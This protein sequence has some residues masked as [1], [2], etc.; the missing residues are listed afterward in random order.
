MSGMRLAMRIESNGLRPAEIATSVLFG[1]DVSAM[2]LSRGPR[3]PPVRALEDSQ[4]AALRRPPCLVAFSGGRDS[5]ALLAVAT[6]AARREGLA[7]PVPVTARYPT[8]EETRESEWQQL[9]V[10][11]LGLTDW[12]RRDFIE[13]AD[14]IGPIARGLME[15]HG[16]QYPYNVHLLAPFMEDARGGTFVTGLGGDEAFTPGSRALAVITGRVRP[17]TRDLLRVTASLAPRPVRRAV[18]ARR[19]LLAFPWLSA[20]ANRAFGLDWLDDQL[21]LPLRWGARQREWRTSRYIHVAIRSMA[22][23]GQ[24]SYV[25]VVHP[26]AE[27]PFID[28]LAREGGVRGFASRS[29]AMDALFGVLLPPEVRRRR[30][31]A[32]FDSVLWNRYTR[33]F[34][35]GLR[36][37]ELD[38]ALNALLLDSIVD[39][40]ALAAHW[41]S[42]SPQANSFLLLQA[43]WLTSRS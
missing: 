28:A 36:D 11:H 13:E 8:L 4:V 7:D 23:I 32:S 29:A 20:D 33:D 9:V 41:S 21:R 2:N 12:V 19:P 39:R 40:P 10:R 24:E 43:C 38:T 35:D 14:L 42:A 37:D 17:A 27:G 25:D 22:K 3:L 34:L 5:S 1:R 31:K 30:S 18:L 15:R 6:R 16:L 26:F